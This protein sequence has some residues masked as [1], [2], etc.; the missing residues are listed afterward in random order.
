MVLKKVFYGVFKAWGHFPSYH[1]SVTNTIF[2]I[3]VIASYIKLVQLN[4]QAG[5]SETTLLIINNFHPI[6]IIIYFNYVISN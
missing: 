1:G 2:H 4:Q 6:G 3:I 5:V